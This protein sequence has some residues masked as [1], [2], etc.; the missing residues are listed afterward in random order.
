MDHCFKENNAENYKDAGIHSDGLSTVVEF[1]SG[2]V[3]LLDY[4]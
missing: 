2:K 4:A 3:A 1:S